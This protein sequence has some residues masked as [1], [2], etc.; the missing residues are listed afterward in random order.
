MKYGIL[1]LMLILM[2]G[3]VTSEINDYAPVKQGECFIAK[4]ICASCSFVNVSIAYPNSTL[5]ISN[6]PMINSGGAVWTYEFCNTTTFGR[7]DISGVGDLEGIDTGFDVLYFEVTP[8]G[9]VLDS[10]S[11]TTLFGSLLVMLILSIVFIIMAM[12]TESLVGKLTLYSIS[13]IGF[14]MVILY[15]VVTIQQVLFGFDSIVNGIETLWFVAKIGITIGSIAFGIVV[16][17]I[18]LKA[19]NIKRGLR[20]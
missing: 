14:I 1:F 19:W 10:A 17:L 16:L 20:D 12:K 3:L 7:Y 8:S 2:S 15:T 4:Q 13:A 6:R 11:S 18:M 5:V 9:S